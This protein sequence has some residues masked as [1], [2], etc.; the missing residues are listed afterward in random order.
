MARPNK[1]KFM[2]SV[3]MATY[4]G[5]RYIKEQ[6]ESI[7]FQTRK[8]DE[9][10]INDDR[11]IDGTVDIIADIKKKYNA[12]IILKVNEKRLGYAQNFREAIRRTKGEIVFLSDQDDV[13]LEN[14]IEI[15]M[16]VF[17]RKEQVLA[18]ST[19]YYLSDG[20]L[21]RQRPSN[22][23]ENERLQLITWKCFMRYPGY[24]GM[25]MAFRKSIWSKVDEQDWKSRA[26]HDWMINQYAA[27]C[28]GMYKTG[29]RTVIYR[30]HGANTEG[31]LLNRQRDDII[32][33]R[34]SL[35]DS[36]IDELQS[37]QLTDSKKEKFVEKAVVF[38]KTRRRILKSG[39]LLYLV[40]YELGKIKFISLRAVLGDVYVCVKGKRR[41]YV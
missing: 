32:Y 36:L 7:L 15:C 41:K 37:I 3:V 27:G 29:R 35:I 1:G 8:P 2:I 20:A 26:A 22:F 34:I 38:E 18:L 25:A 16:A 4:N 17:E 31:I 23:F 40:L 28:G 14:K 39:K 33:A 9:I 5:E 12:P 21:N 11:S 24:P 6:L 19:A 30:Q 10:I 13:W